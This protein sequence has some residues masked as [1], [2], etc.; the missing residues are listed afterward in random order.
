MLKDKSKVEVINYGVSGRT[1]MKKGDYPYWN[2]NAFTQ[3]KE[4]NPDKVVMMLGTNDAKNF[5]WDQTAYMQD[6]LEMINIFKNLDSKPEVY[7]MIP[8]PLYQDGVYSMEQ[9][10]INEVFPELI[11]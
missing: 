3:A 11:P 8:P 4:S 9:K 6:W 5:Q 1:A 2:E 7:V 10:V